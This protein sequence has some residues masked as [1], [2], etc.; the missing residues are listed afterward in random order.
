MNKIRR[1]TTRNEQWREPLLNTTSNSDSINNIN[2]S[3]SG[4]PE[5]SD[6]ENYPFAD[7]EVFH[8]RFQLANSHPF[9]E[10]S[11]YQVDF[12]YRTSSGLFLVEVTNGQTN[13]I[14]KNALRKIQSALPSEVKIEPGIN[15]ARE[16]LWSFIDSAESDINEI[17]V[18]DRGEVY[19]WNELE[20]V[21]RE[22]VAYN[23][24]IW[25]ADLTF[26]R[27]VD[28]E[29]RNINVTYESDTLSI[30]TSEADDRE[31][32][33]QIFEREVMA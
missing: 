19:N 1:A 4:V 25:S 8:G 24:K 17:N 13:D 16:P 11:P 20:E 3:V 33:L 23:Y 14:A 29:T 10:L 31:Y 27:T 12:Y 9:K 32:V 18:I 30:A 28:G 21:D 22:E 15:E 26:T 6:V 2:I 5:L 7:Q